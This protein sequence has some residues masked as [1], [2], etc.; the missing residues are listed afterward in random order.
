MSPIDVGIEF[1]VF[2]DSNIISSSFSEDLKTSSGDLWRLLP[3]SKFSLLKTTGTFWPK[4]NSKISTSHFTG[5][6]P[7]IKESKLF[8]EP[9]KYKINEI[10]IFYHLFCMAYFAKILRSASGDFDSE[11]GRSQ[12]EHH[13]QRHSLGH[14]N[15]FI[16]IWL[17][18]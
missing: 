7:V 15:L 10:S 13:R 12:I 1:E 4:V 11:R 6:F 17:F 14:R 3:V 18:V 9:V 8:Y 2:L 5:H 16:I